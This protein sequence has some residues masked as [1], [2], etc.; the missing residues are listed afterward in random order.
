MNIGKQIMNTMATA[1]IA[2]TAK[3]KTDHNR[4]E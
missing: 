4:M 2:T 3:E 1:T